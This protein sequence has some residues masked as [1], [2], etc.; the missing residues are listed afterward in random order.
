MDTETFLLERE[1]LEARLTQRRVDALGHA[2]ARIEQHD[3][4][5]GK[6]LPYWLRFA[7]STL[8]T[9]K[10]GGFWPKA[11]LTMAPMLFGLAKT[12]T[13]Q[14]RKDPSPMGAILGF[15]PIVKSLI[16]RYN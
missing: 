12:V 10:F 2:A 1:R 16:K 8:V 9:G 5:F 6:A 15:F 13:G 11:L 7:A 14:V 3:G 4:W